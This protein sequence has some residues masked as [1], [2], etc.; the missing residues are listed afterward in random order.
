[1]RSAL[2]AAMDVSPWRWRDEH[3]QRERYCDGTPVTGPFNSEV[4]EDVLMMQAFGIPCGVYWIDRPW[5]LGSRWGYDD[6]EIDPQRLPN[7]AEMVKWLN[8]NRMEMLLW[9][10]PFYQGEMMDEALSKGYNLAGQ[11]RPRNGNN[12]PMVDLTSPQAR[13][14]GEDGIAITKAGVAR[15]SS[16]VAKTFLRTGPIRYLTAVRSRI[17]QRVRCDVHQAVYDGG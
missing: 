15:S 1:M 6:F 17:T 2:S 10:A 7:F 4:M 13:K 5:G 14:Y 11:E 8:R 9:I 16:I 12:Y 3:T